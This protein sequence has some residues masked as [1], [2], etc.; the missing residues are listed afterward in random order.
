MQKFKKMRKLQTDEIIRISV[1]EFME[2]EKIPVVVV[3]DN[4]RSQHNIGSVFR[5]ADAF[6]I[7]AV[8]LC[9]ITAM[10]PSREIQKTALGATESVV[11]K[12]YDST[13]QSITE[14]KEAGYHIVSIEQV[15]GSIMVQDFMP[16]SGK[17]A[18]VLG[19]E[20]HGIADDIIDLSD[21][22]LEIPQAGTKHSLNIAVAAGIVLWEFFSKLNGFK[23]VVDKSR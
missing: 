8:H 4:I 17:Y 22:C 11:W 10:P 23:M 9:G 1:T 3:L 2:A 6:R 19:N 18:L 16:D 15:S 13:R 5:T 7:E 12:Y 20:V 14:L 21:S